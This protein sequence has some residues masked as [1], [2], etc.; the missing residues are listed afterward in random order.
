MYYVGLDIHKKSIAYCVKRPDGEIVREGT[1]AARREDLRIWAAAL[2]QPWTG[3]M[4]ATLF[5]DGV[6]DH[7]TPFAAALKMGHPARMRAI[8]TSKKKTDRLDAR[9]ICD[10]LRCDLLPPAFVMPPQLRQ[11]R[12]VLRYRHLL[13]RASVQMQNKI[14]GLL[15]EMGVEYDT[16]RLHRK[17][18]FGQLIEDQQAEIPASARHLLA[19]S[20]EQYET[21]HRMELQLLRGLEQHPDIAQRVARLMTIPGV[22]PVLGLT[23][24]L[25]VGPVERLGNLSSDQF[26][27]A[28]ERAARIR[29]Q[30]S[31]RS[32]LQTTQRASAD[33]VD[34]GRAPGFALES[35]A[36][37]SA[38]AR[39]PA[40]PSEPGHLG[41][42]S[43]AGG[44][45]HGCG[46]GPSAAS[47]RRAGGRGWVTSVSPFQRLRQTRQAG[48]SATSRYA[49]SVCIRAGGGDSQTQTSC[50]QFPCDAANGCLATCW[51]RPQ[52][53]SPNSLKSN[54]N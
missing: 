24:A 7:L 13:V 8:A 23:W 12:R 43:Q 47:A 28:I 29:R 11:L 9:T 50:A 20:R 6:H 17:R 4:E 18:Y 34:R 37:P 48:D 31:A 45:S 22:G 21:L 10:L 26:L 51:L 46:P 44:V 52:D 27:R 19:F 30:A 33:R 41:R 35:S 38:G 16:P 40:R 49:A 25:E 36:G 3:A 54:A 5:S 14:A 32:D 42:S 15:L 2:P 1:V 53:G 39:T